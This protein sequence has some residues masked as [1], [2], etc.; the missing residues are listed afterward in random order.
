M[1]PHPGPA[2]LQVAWVE[3]QPPC[4]QGSHRRLG[5]LWE[6]GPACREPQLALAWARSSLPSAL[7]RAPDSEEK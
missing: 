4:L 6:P 5:A 7:G 2:G 1:S 3:G